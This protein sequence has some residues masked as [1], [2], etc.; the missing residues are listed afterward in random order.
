MPTGAQFYYSN[1]FFLID[2]GNLS[3]EYTGYVI[4]V[5]TPPR[6]RRNKQRPVNCNTNFLSSLCWNFAFVNFCQVAICVQNIFLHPK[7][8][9]EAILHFLINE[10]LEQKVTAIVI[11]RG[12]SFIKQVF[13]D[14]V[15]GL[16][17][18]V[19]LSCLPCL[20]SQFIFMVVIH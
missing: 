16:C 1:L 8:K 7:S 2:V 19:S 10:K 11:L 6:H 4:K 9:L 13:Q 14:F 20:F 3:F 5:I 17:D 18:D 12:M 15:K